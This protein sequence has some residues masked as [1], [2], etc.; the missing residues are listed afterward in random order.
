MRSKLKPTNPVVP[1]ANPIEALFNLGKNPR[2]TN[3]IKLKNKREKSNTL[4]F[5]L[6]NILKNPCNPEEKI[7]FQ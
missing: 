7:V 3:R 1:I 4:K 6:A 5:N 2:S